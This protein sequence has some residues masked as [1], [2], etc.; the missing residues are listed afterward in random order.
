VAAIV[1]VSSAARL[2]VTRRAVLGERMRRL[3]RDLMA[4][5]EHPETA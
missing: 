2:N 5:A 3:A 4:R 1:L